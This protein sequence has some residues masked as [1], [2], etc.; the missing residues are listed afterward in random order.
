MSALFV[1]GAGTEIGKTYVACALLRAWREGGVACDAFK[2]V[3]SGFE[4]ENAVASD[5]GL[6]L[7]A[8]GQSVSHEAI[9]RMSPWRFRAPLAP[10][11]AAKAEGAVIDMGAVVAA[12]AARIEA[13]ADRLLLIE[14]AG[15][16]MAPLTQGETNL[17]LI[18]ALKTPVIFVAGSYLGAVSHALTGL[19]VLDARG[20]DLRV[21]IVSESE[22]SIGLEETSAMIG[23]MRPQQTIALARRN[24]PHWS[25]FVA[26]L[27]AAQISI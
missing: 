26:R 1:T 2:P 21:V 14:G 25:G 7:G 27:L 11:L 5:P 16:V 18:V 4:S 9:A 10:P 13:N 19:S 8:L 23:S 3:V 12:C 20:I 22:N 15:G 17:D 6:L 24:D